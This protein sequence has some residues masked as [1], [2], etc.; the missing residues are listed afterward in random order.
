MKSKKKQVR[1]RRVGFSASDV[2]MAI[3]RRVNRERGLDNLSLAF[4]LVVRE[5]DRDHKNG[6]SNG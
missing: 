4:R 5:W 2:E 6:G 1:F 3:L